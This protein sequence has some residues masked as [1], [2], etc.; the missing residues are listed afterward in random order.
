MAQAKSGN[1]SQVEV[2]QAASAFA[3]AHNISHSRKVTVVLNDLC[4][5]SC[6]VGV[7]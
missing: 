2:I 1:P 7:L 6:N 5:P 4:E 3:K